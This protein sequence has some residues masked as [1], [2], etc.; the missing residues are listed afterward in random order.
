MRQQYVTRGMRRRPYSVAAGIREQASRL[1]SLY[2][3]RQQQA[4]QDKQIELGESNLALEQQRLRQEGKQFKKQMS[5]E[6]DAQGIAEAG[7]YLKGGLSAAKLGMESDVWQPGIDRVKGLWSGAQTQAT[8]DP[9]GDTRT[10]G[11]TFQSQRGPQPSSWSKFA[12][13]EWK[14]G[15]WGG[16][17]GGL[18]GAGA[19]KLVGAKKK[20]QTAAAGAAGGMFSTW[21]AGGSSPWSMALGGLLGG[22]LGALF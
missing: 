6:K 11:G 12:G 4:F 9:S 15:A 10:G 17:T 2:A 7:L 20:W 3:L 5:L 21:M 13:G 8:G 19:A 18:M 22:G 1:P 14:S 16:V